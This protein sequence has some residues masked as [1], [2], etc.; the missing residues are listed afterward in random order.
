MDC[1]HAITS[2]YLISPHDSTIAES[3]VCDRSA[4]GELR[5]DSHSRHIILPVRADHPYIPPSSKQMHQWVHPF[6]VGALITFSSLV[7]GCTAHFQALAQQRGHGKDSAFSW[8]IAFSI[9]IF[10]AVCIEALALLIEFAGFS[11]RDKWSKL[12]KLCMGIEYMM[13][14]LGFVAIVLAANRIDMKFIGGCLRHPEEGYV[15]NDRVCTEWAISLTF[16]IL[17]E[18]TIVAN[19]FSHGIGS[20]K[21]FATW[22]WRF[23]QQRATAISATPRRRA[24]TRLQ[25]PPPP[26]PPIPLPDI[27]ALP[28]EPEPAYDVPAAGPNTIEKHEQSS[29]D[30]E[31]AFSS[32]N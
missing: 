9:I 17:L 13:L 1:V 5:W 12:A 14:P 8:I 27:C 32:P 4:P 24:S 10:L 7:L 2:P 16:T 22:S 28:P 26:P 11:S 23:R 21:A 20:P 6:T 15:V 30:Q 25:V 18:V 29:K 31:Q 3:P 19:A